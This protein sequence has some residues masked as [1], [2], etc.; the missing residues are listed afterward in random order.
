M[1]ELFEKYSNTEVGPFIFDTL[2]AMCIISNIQLASRHP[3]NNGPSIKIAISAA[4][5]MQKSIAEKIPELNK[6]MEMGWNPEFDV[7]A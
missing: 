6:I 1:N 7:P 2:T 5:E 4:K 3:A